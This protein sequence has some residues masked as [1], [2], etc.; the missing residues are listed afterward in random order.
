M[1][2]RRKC[3]KVYGRVESNKRNYDPVYIKEYA[4]VSIMHIHTQEGLAPKKIA[5]DG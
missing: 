1:I 5:E 3:G 4:I 2:N